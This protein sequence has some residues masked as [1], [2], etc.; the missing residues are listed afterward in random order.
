[1]MKRRDFILASAGVA[2]AMIPGLSRAAQPCPPPQISLSGGTTATTSCTITTG[3]SYST[4]FDLAESSISEGGAWS[5]LAAGWKSIRTTGGRA[6]ATAYTDSY[7]D[8]YA[9]LS[10]FPPNVQSEATIYKNGPGYETEL[11]L[12]MAHTSS[13]VR[14]YECL[15]NV[16]GGGVAI[17][18]W[19]GP[20]GD[21]T[22]LRLSV[23]G[24]SPVAVTGDKI[25]AR[26]VGSLIRLWHIPVKTGV[27]VLLAE[28][29]DSTFA[30]GQP[31]IAFYAHSPV[32]LTDYG[33]SD[34]SVISV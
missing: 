18:R 19:N 26:I 21:F 27:P 23:Y 11:L 22:F 10:G 1:M 3:R 7:D 17:V 30:D 33:F 12:R 9:I 6:H 29:T 14:G 15:F 16:N 2:G 31:G 20:R 34:Y 13:S 24:G 32:V 5:H 28:A 25:R 4:S 8:A